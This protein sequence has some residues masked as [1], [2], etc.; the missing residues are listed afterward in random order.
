MTD[1]DCEVG[2]A[3]AVTLIEIAGDLDAQ[4]AATYRPRLATAVAAGRPVV[5]D[6]GDCTFIDGLGAR[7]L[8]EAHRRASEAG[9]PLCVVLPYSAASS[10]RR[11]L[12]EF[13]PD[14]VSFPIVAT[15]T[16][17]SPRTD[18]NVAD[19]DALEVGLERIR[20]LRAGLWEAGSRR[21]QLLADRDALLLRLRAG[22]AAYRE[23]SARRQPPH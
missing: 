5:V 3:A 10:V 7:L 6:L 12:L 1:V 4:A 22:L 23:N 13:A 2:S 8:A 19:R 21:D 11:L 15:R 16:A 18:P 14:L 17:A 9:I 20:E